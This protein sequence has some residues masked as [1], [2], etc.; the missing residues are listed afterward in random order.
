MSLSVPSSSSSL[1]SSSSSSS[2]LTSSASSSS[3]KSISS[4]P[5]TTVSTNAMATDKPSAAKQLTEI[6]P[7]ES[8]YQ[9]AMKQ[10]SVQKSATFKTILRT[11]QKIV[12][13]LLKKVDLSTRRLRLDNLVVKKFITSVEGASLLLEAVGYKKIEI[14]SSGKKLGYFSIEEKEV[15]SSALSRAVELIQARLEELDKPEPSTSSATTTQPKKNIVCPCGFWGDEK[16][17]GLCSL[18][19]KKKYFGKSVEMKEKKKEEP[20]QCLGKGC[21]FFGNEK[22]RGY[23]SQCYSKEKKSHPEWEKPKWKKRWRAT[24]LKLKAV[25]RF[26]LSIIHPVQTEKNRCWLCRR[27]VGIT[28]IECRCGYIFCGKHRYPDEHNCTF[29]HKSFHKKKLEKINV[30][31]KGSKFDRIGGEEAEDD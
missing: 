10:L 5:T 23:C 31:V 16:T 3:S 4:S 28:G 15:D 6:S 21:R 25:R 2:S 8:K 1:S 19:Y 22:L 17:E 11:A 26:Q 7:L 24:V 13:D 18:C 30:E 9:L 14:E 12:K 27:R 20:K 29:D